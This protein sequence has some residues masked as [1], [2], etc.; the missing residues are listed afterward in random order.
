MDFDQSFD[1]QEN[2][3]TINEIESCISN[4]LTNPVLA[5]AKINDNSI[6]D[7]TDKSVMQTTKDIMNNSFQERGFLKEDGRLK[8][9][10]ELR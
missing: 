6:T 2:T 1:H 4:A 10:K 3:I 8:I 5:D 7:T 9:Q